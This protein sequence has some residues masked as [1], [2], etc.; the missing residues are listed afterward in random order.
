MNVGKN[1]TLG[2]RDVPEE[3]VQLLI[4][5]YGELKVTRDDTGFLVVTGSI[6][7]EFEN[8]GSE[9][10]EN[11]SEVDRGTCDGSEASFDAS[12]RDTNQHRRA[13]HSYPCEGDDGYGQRGKRDRPWTSD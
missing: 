4:V 2:D 1:T 8:L 9:V 11:G 7:S 6:A 10:L 13:E 12:W 5:A 3:L